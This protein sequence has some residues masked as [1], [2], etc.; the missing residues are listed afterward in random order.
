MVF[1]GKRY[2][3]NEDTDKSTPE[4]AEHAKN[5]NLSLVVPVPEDHFT[6]FWV[7]S[8]EN[9]EFGVISGDFESFCCDFWWQ[10]PLICMDLQLDMSQ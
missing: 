10:L 9:C 8:C 7:R 6:D 5:P 2:H 1:T 3:I 4:T